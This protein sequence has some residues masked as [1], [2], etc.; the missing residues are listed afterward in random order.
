MRDWVAVKGPNSK[1]HHMHIQTYIHTYIYICRHMV[2]N[3]VS[4]SFS[5]KD[6]TK[7]ELRPISALACG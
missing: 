6:G 1:F 4:G 2:N 7:S 3:I 5:A